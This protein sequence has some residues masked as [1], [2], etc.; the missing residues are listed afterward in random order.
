M[1]IV[2]IIIGICLI[3]AAISFIAIKNKRKKD[4]LNN[5]FLEAVDN[6]NLEKAKALLAKGA[7]VN[8]LDEFGETALISQSREG[9]IEFVKF[10]LEN[11]ADVNLMFKEEIEIHGDPNGGGGGGKMIRKA[12]PLHI[13]LEY[14]NMLNEKREPIP[15]EW[16]DGDYDAYMISLEQ[17]KKNIKEIINIL[18]TAD[19]KDIE[20]YREWNLLDIIKKLI[21]NY[22]EDKE[23]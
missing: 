11:N 13:L 19:A 6:D 8:A 14:S 4:I 12:S 5:Q 3:I 17:K 16:I 10:L 22:K 23:D 18:K 15:R 2:L 20:I 1:K 7:D 9:N 21:D